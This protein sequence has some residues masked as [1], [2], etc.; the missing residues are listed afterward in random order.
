[1]KHM[2][3]LAGLALLALLGGA[4]DVARRPD[5][6]PVVGTV[7]IGPDPGTL[8]V[9]PQAGR[10]FIG[11]QSSGRVDVLDTATGTLVHTVAPPLAGTQVDDLAADERLGRV[12]V[13]SAPGIGSPLL[14]GYVSVLDARS[15][16]LLHTT[17]VTLGGALGA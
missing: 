14:R 3:I 7:A 6:N 9:D 16:R 8:V 10:A 1:M 4:M 11:D 13:L 15:G 12:F 17:P 2:P 5:G